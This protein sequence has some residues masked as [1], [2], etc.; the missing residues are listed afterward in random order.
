MT[1]HKSKGLEFPV[2][3]LA[4]MAKPFNRQDLY[5]PFLMH[6]ELGFGPRFVE[7]ETRVSYPTLPYL[8]INRRS[9]LELL[10]EEMRVLYV[11]LTRPRDKMIL[12]GTVRDLPRAVS[13]WTGMQGREE[14]LLAD[15]LLARG[16]SYLDWVGPALIRHPGAAILRKLAGAEGIVS[17]VLHGDASNWSISVQAASDLGQVL[18][19]ARRMMLQ[20][21]KNGGLSRMRFARAVHCVH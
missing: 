1:I 6:K 10:A 4:G 14:L 5:S 18:L 9:R 17:T 20:K 11:G 8:A 3:F 12:V 15:H 19:P 7:R 2:V 21:V 13:G 16:R